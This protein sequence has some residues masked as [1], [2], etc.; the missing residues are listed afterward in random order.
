VLDAG[1]GGGD[2]A[3]AAEVAIESIQITTG[4]L[5][6]DARAAGPPEGEL[7]MLLHGFPQTSIEWRLQLLALGNAGYRAVAPDQRGYSPGAR[8]SDV[9]SYAIALLVGDVVNMAEALGYDRFHVAGHDW[10]GGVAWGVEGVLPERVLSLTAVSPP[11]PDAMAAE[12]SD[13]ES[14]QYAAS[15]YFELFTAPDATVAVLGELGD[16]SFGL[17]PEDSVQEYAD[18]VL[19]DPE[20]FDLALNWYR[21]NV[22]DRQFPGGIGQV[23]APTLYLWGAD[24]AYF[25]RETA[26]ATADYVDGPYEFVEVEGVGHWLPELGAETVNE[27]ML[28]HTA[29]N[30]Q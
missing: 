8:P 26:E 4:D 24:D 10:G 15:A 25:C 20:V 11:H 23:S 14:C 28:A 5:V 1:S 6:F 27:K 12:L 30:G 17:L 18:K 2:D 16:S 13:P 29:R 9:E 22:E 19:S 21:A 3:V 7:V